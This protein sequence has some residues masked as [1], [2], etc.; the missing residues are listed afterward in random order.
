MTT[1]TRD[2]DD[3]ADD[4]EED[5]MSRAGINI[6]KDPAKMAAAMVVDAD[7]QD[8]FTPQITLQEMLKT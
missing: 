4:I 8:E 5:P 6:Y 1:D 3:F 7:G 2:F